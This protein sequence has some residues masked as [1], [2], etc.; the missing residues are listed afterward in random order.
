MTS[1]L[2]KSLVKC[3]FQ[4]P[5]QHTFWGSIW[6]PS[7]VF[8]H[9]ECSLPLVFPQAVRKHIAFLPTIR[10][11]SGKQTGFTWSVIVTGLENKKRIIRRSLGRLSSACSVFIVRRLCME[12]VWRRVENVMVPWN[13]IDCCKM[14]PGR[15]VK[16]DVAYSNWKSLG[17]VCGQSHSVTVFGAQC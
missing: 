14:V 7:Q 12:M 3:L 5:W 9:T 6:K 15:L 10:L 11:V 17:R 4:V 13:C 8:N 2:G 16:T 1:D